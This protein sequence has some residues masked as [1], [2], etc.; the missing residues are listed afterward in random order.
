MR[1]QNVPSQ[2][3]H[4]LT[5]PLFGAAG[6]LEVAGAD[7]NRGVGRDRLEPGKIGFFG[8]LLLALHASRAREA[9]H[10]LS[11]H[12]HLIEYARRHPLT[13]GNRTASPEGELPHG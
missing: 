11:R 4:G 12:A 10:E 1:P 13:F 2:G 3:S 6:G 7:G 8:H 5:S 9:R